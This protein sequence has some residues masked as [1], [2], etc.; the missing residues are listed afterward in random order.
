MQMGVLSYH[1]NVHGVHTFPALLELKLYPIVFLDL[2]PQA[3]HMDK[4]LGVGV[5]MLNE[6]KAFAFIEE[7]YSSRVF[8]VLHGN[9][10][11]GNEMFL[12]IT[13]G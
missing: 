10:F 5:V 4:S 13:I 1:A 9:N 7:L 2:V 3:A 6:T 11:W 12:K 8:F